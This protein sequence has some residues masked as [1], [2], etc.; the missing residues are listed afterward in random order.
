V[1]SSPTFE[2][3]AA[4]RDGAMTRSRNV[5]SITPT[6]EAWSRRMGRKIRDS[7]KY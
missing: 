2:K 1:V 5:F 6:N 7:Q 4:R 3:S